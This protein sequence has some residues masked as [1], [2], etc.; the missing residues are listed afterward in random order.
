MTFYQ[1]VGL[2]LWSRIFRDQSKLRT[3]DRERSVAIEALE[4][5]REQAP[6]GLLTQL[7]DFWMPEGYED[8]K[9]FHFCSEQ[10]GDSD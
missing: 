10:S 9:G 2:W 6:L 1:Q 5:A 8:Q 4:A 7:F 3:W